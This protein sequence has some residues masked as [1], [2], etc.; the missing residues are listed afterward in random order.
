MTSLKPIQAE[1]RQG[2]AL[3]RVRIVDTAP[4]RIFILM[5][6][7]ASEL[8]GPNVLLVGVVSKFSHVPVS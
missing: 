3:Y 7:I 2:E 6:D 5:K 4:T 1:N 8:A